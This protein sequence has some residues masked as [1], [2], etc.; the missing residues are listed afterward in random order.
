MGDHIEV[1]DNY[2]VYWN[3]IERETES[4]KVYLAKNNTTSRVILAKV[5]KD[6]LSQ[7]KKEIDI[8]EQIG[9]I[10]SEY[11]TK[12]LDYKTRKT[13]TIIF[14]EKNDCLLS[15]FLKQGGILPESE[16][17]YYMYQLIKGLNDIHQTSYIH[18]GIRP[19]NIFLKGKNLCLGNLDLRSDCD[20]RQ[21]LLGTYT[22]ISPEIIDVSVLGSNRQTYS[23]SV[24]LWSAGLIFYEML[25]GVRPFKLSPK[26][27]VT[28]KQMS[29]LILESCGENLSFPQGNIIKKETKDLVRL[30]LD[31]K[32][33]SKL[34]AANVLSSDC[35]M[36]FK[37]RIEKA[38]EINL[39][40]STINN[41]TLSSSI[42][43]TSVLISKGHSSNIESIDNLL[44]M[45]SLKQ[46]LANENSK[47]IYILKIS[48][49][50]R[51]LSNALRKI[52]NSDPA[53]FDKLQRFCQ[54]VF[55]LGILLKNSLFH[56]SRE[57]EKA[58]SIS[59]QLNQLI[60][61][62]K[63]IL[64]GSID[65][66]RWEQLIKQDPEYFKTKSELFSKQ[67][68]EAYHDIQREVKLYQANFG[69]QEIKSVM[70][71]NNFMRTKDKKGFD[72]YFQRQT[73]FFMKELIENIGYLGRREEKKIC[74]DLIA[75]IYSYR[76]CTGREKID[77][78]RLNV[79]VENLPLSRKQRINRDVVD[80]PSQHGI[81]IG[82]IRVF[83]AVLVF[84]CLMM[85]F[86]FGFAIFD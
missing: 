67:K 57:I 23:Y 45:N 66:K 10:D 15:D 39:Y 26:K 81:G 19:D 59:N 44:L 35:F 9:K 47:N 51:A 71:T 24:D 37:F 79:K 76:Q 25:F 1:I 12:M 86:Y 31:Y 32:N 21:K 46:I 70:K 74:Q 17:L 61:R 27:S 50:I 58:L 43:N 6:N 78:E 5:Y 56:N 83:P 22:Y 4:F 28:M 84:S 52:K 29:K 64:K 63:H 3:V 33:S 65:S 34:T 38:A 72:S 53:R 68:H 82:V 11:L 40:R 48:D 18:R 85:I 69:A 20:I 54:K 8:L 14:F 36:R 62:N 77:W 75:L 2:T 55:Q 13:E 7:A 80:M 42:M 60:K 41:S 49:N 73:V 30:M 16:V